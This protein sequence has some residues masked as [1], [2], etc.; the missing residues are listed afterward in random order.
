MGSLAAHAPFTSA[1]RALTPLASAERTILFS[2][3]AD[4]LVSVV[5]LRD[6]YLS[7]VLE[8][9]RGNKSRAARILGIDRRTLYRWLDEAARRRAGEEA[10]LAAS[11]TA[12]TDDW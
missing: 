1:E 9:V 8:V 3:R 6:L 10:A 4:E 7:H 11:A 2:P 12:S 5:V